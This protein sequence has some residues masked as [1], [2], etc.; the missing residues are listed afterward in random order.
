MLP[1]VRERVYEE[2]RMSGSGRQ[3]QAF[4][5]KSQGWEEECNQSLT[6]TDTSRN[7]DLLY[8]FVR[9]SG[10]IIDTYSNVM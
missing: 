4:L 3:R 9:L 7:Y 6:D 1:G 5:L 8:V 2:E 10:L